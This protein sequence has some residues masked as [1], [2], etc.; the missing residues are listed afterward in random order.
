MET[1]RGERVALE[2]QRKNKKKTVMNSEK[3]GKNEKR[4]CSAE[5]LL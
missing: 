5:V 1:E 2:E 4:Q 3:L